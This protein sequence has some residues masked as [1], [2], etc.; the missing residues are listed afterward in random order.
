MQ[1]K[2]AR[3]GVIDRRI[4]EPQTDVSYVQSAVFFSRRSENGCKK[5]VQREAD[6]AGRTPSSCRFTFAEYQSSNP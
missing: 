2:T 6:F 1:R 3:K 5:A 4:K